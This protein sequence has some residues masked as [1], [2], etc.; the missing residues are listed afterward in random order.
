MDCGVGEALRGLP[1]P[2]RCP[3]RR[4]AARDGRPYGHEGRRRTGKRKT[5]D[6]R[7]RTAGEKQSVVRS[8][9]SGAK[10]KTTGAGLCSGRLVSA[11]KAGRIHAAAT[12]E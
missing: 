12:G 11:E 9:Q 7:P 1:S 3:V 4:R 8:R 10:R 5:A 6:G 2:M